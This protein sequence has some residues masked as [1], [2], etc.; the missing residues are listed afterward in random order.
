MSQIYLTKIERKTIFTKSLIFVL[1]MFVISDL[2]VTGPF[3][4]NFIPWLYILG[5]VGSIKK[6]DGVLMGII[7]TFTVFIASLITQNGAILSA[8]STAIIAL[9]LLLLGIFTGKIIHEFVLEHRLVKYIKPSKKV[10]YTASIV[11]MV[12]VSFITVGL[13]N[14]NIISYLKSRNNLKEYISQTYK[15]DEYKITSTNFNRKVKGKYVYKVNID[16][17][18]ICFVPITKTVFKDVNMSERLEKLNN[19]LY[20][21]TEEAINTLK[22]NYKLLKAAKVSYKLEYTNFGV[23][24]DTVVLSIECKQDEENIDMLYHEIENFVGEALKIK[25]ANRIVIT[26][27]NESLEILEKDIR[28]I[29]VEYIKDGFEIEEISE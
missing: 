8:I 10:I 6:I 5:T 22:S 4:F 26:I 19:K 7:G 12:I 2:T 18:E 21:E 13:Y 24:P 1:I 25:T 15:I 9:V 16:D 20:S 3:Y 28:K 29:T 23:N 27:N 11:S 14:G 17:Q